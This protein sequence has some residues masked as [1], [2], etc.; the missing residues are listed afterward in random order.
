MIAVSGDGVR[1]VTDSSFSRDTWH[2]SIKQQQQQQRLQPAR[3]SSFN[4]SG[5]LRCPEK[6]GKQ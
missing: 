6:T 4:P 1:A 3:K 2:T 5:E